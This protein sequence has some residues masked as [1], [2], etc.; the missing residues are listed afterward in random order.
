MNE[1]PARTAEQRRRALLRANRI[2]YARARLKRDV[3]ADPSLRKLILA[4][5]LRTDA[6][7]LEDGDLDTMKVAELLLA[8]PKFGR[9][10]VNRRLGAH[11]ISHSKT[12]GGLSPRQREDLID[13]IRRTPPAPSFNRST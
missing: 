10:K 11:R 13:S 8:A 7:G 12:L 2:R 5:A 1:T 3:G 6:L 9:V 4:L